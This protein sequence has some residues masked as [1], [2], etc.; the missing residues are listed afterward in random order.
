[1]RGAAPASWP[2]ALIDRR[3]VSCRSGCWRGLGG[4]VL[5]DRLGHRLGHGPL[6][7]EQLDGEHVLAVDEFAHSASHLGPGGGEVGSNTVGD[8]N[9]TL[10]EVGGGGAGL[11]DA[12]K[13]GGLHVGEPVENG[14]GH[15]VE[16]PWFVGGDRR[17]V[18]SG[19]G[20]VQ[21]QQVLQRESKQKQE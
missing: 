11:V 18:S 20:P 7:L 1:M 17:S 8:A 2:A 4:L 5:G 15:G 19:G 6:P 13:D 9:G 14:V 16:P 21:K 12:V 3:A 10:G